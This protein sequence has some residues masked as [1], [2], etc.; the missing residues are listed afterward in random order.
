MNTNKMTDEQIS[1]LADGELSEN[2]IDMALATL[3]QPEGHA[4][5]DVYHQIGDV[6]RSNDMAVSLS[7]DFATRMAVRL[8]AEPTV[9]AS[10]ISASSGMSGKKL[11]NGCLPVRRAISRFVLPGAVAAAAATVAF[12]T[13]PQLLVAT[14]G[15]PENVNAPAVVLAA[16]PVSPIANVSSVAARVA[17][18]SAVA[19]E[20]TILRDPRIDAYLMAHQRFSPSVYSTAQFARSATFATDSHK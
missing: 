10:A 4:A 12:M 5:W 2:H 15:T 9:I 6:L 8:E 11:S 19:N 3:R 7:P 1:A 13:A 18:S 17:S 14:K 16:R 20:G